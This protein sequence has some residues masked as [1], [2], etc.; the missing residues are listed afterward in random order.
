MQSENPATNA[1]FT[2]REPVW[3]LSGL[4]GVTKGQPQVRRHISSPFG[5]APNGSLIHTLRLIVSRILSLGLERLPAIARAS[6]LFYRNMLRICVHN[7][8]PPPTVSLHLSSMRRTLKS[9]ASRILHF[10][11]RH[12]NGNATNFHPETGSRDA[13][14]ED[15]GVEQANMTET[16][17]GS[18]TTELSCS[19]CTTYSHESCEGPTKPVRLC[20]LIHFDRA[21]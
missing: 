10:V 17:V 5:V 8:N 14:D 1:S 13:E 2:P 9:H 7:P 21:Y 20:C 12:S 11:S 19:S 4:S 3:P 15:Y 16:L 6:A 18:S